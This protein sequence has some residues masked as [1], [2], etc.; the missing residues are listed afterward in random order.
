MG[1][2]TRAEQVET[3]KVTHKKSCHQRCWPFTF[4]KTSIRLAW[5]FGFSH[6]HVSYKYSACVL[7]CISNYLLTYKCPKYVSSSILLMDI[8]PVIQHMH[9][10][11]TAVVSNCHAILAK[12]FLAF[13]IVLLSVAPGITRIQTEFPWFN[14][15]NLQYIEIFLEL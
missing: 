4:T 12:A 11:Q 1:R 6:T 3:W 13:L 15:L 9:C 7:A 14:C 2:E 5:M 8:Q 10:H